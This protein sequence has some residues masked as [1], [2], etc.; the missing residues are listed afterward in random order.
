MGQYVA[1]DLEGTLTTGG[2]WKGINRYMQ[3]HH[4]YWRYLSHYVPNYLWDRYTVAGYGNRDKFKVHLVNTM[5]TMFRGFDMS[6]LNQM[7]SWIVENELWPKRRLDVL[8]ELAKLDS[9][10]SIVLVSGTYDNILS[11]FGKKIN[12]R[13]IV[14][15]T[16]IEIIN[17]RSTGRILGEPN[18]GSVKVLRLKNLLGESELISTFSDGFADIPMLELSKFPVAVYPD[19][20]LKKVANDRNWRVLPSGN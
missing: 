17:G 2:I 16:Q 3:Y 13:V 20:K 12:N 19:D 7:G 6:L 14:L 11:E 10:V 15:G 4:Y 5:Q 9:R 8:E 18:Q 1:V